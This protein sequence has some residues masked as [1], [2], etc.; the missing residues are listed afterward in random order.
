ME[1]YIRLNLLFL[2][3]FMYFQFSVLG[4]FDTILNEL[5]DE[6]FVREDI[7]NVK[8]DEDHLKR[9]PECGT[10]LER[11][12][13]PSSSSRISNS[14]E[15]DRHY[16]WMIKVERENSAID[17]L[18]DERIIPCGGVIIT[19]TTAITASHCICGEFRRDYLISLFRLE[20]YEKEIKPWVSC[21]GGKYARSPPNEVVSNGLNTNKIRVRLGGKDILKLRSIKIRIAYVMA[22]LKYTVED[23]KDIGEDIGLLITKNKKGKGDQFYDPTFSKVNSKV[24]PHVNFDVGS[25]CLAAEKKEVPHMYEGKVV[26]VGWGLRYEDVKDDLTGKPKRGKHTCLTN[27][28]GPIS[29]R[30]RHCDVDDLTFTSNKWGCHKDVKPPEYDTEEKCDK[31]LAKAEKFVEKKVRTLDRSESLSSLWSLTNKIKVLSSVDN[32]EHICYKEQLFKENGWCYVDSFNERTQEIPW[33]FCGS[34]CELMQEED[35]EPSIYHKMIW[36]FPFSRPTHC[37]AWWQASIPNSFYLC[38]VS[39]LPQTSVFQFVSKK[40]TLRRNSKLKD[41]VIYKETPEQA[42]PIKENIEERDF[43]GYQMTL[44]GDSGSPHWMYSSTKKRRALIGITSFGSDTS[45]EMF[46]DH[47]LLTTHPNVLKWI[48]RHSGIGGSP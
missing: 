34:S 14:E 44:K 2:L 37:S 12:N 35:S 45:R 10:L 40:R 24:R 25:L 47:I 11:E 17:V 22:E 6:N 39:S 28:F 33:G 9:N 32:K 26:T 48:K 41:M 46:A 7:G 1:N 36:E 42:R 3:E 13:N 43:I 19:Q 38:I 21:K 31:Y 18:I 23:Y 5:L 29:A 4:S 20:F 27:Q 16:P 8:I 30:F 15:S